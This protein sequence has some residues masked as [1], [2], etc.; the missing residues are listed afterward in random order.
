MFAITSRFITWKLVEDTNICS[1][2]LQIKKMDEV[3]AIARI[4]MGVVRFSVEVVKKITIKI[5]FN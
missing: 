4:S 3:R 2:F 1:I 5:F